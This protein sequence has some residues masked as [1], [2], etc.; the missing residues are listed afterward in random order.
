MSELD[1]YIHLPLS[2]INS[3]RLAVL[4][5][6]EFEDELHITIQEHQLRNVKNDYGIIQRDKLAED[7]ETDNSSNDSEAEQGRGTNE[8]FEANEESTSERTGTDKRYGSDKEV[9]DEE[10][11]DMRDKYEALSY[12]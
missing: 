12:C 8:E 4:H 5:P 9:R 7:S 6:G 2:T 10:L 1:K 11:D 3:I